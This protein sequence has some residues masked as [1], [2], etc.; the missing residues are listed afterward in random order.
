VL[1]EG[2]P[3]AYTGCSVTQCASVPSQVVGTAATVLIGS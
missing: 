2:K 3:A 1:L